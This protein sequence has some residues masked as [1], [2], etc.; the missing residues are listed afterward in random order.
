MFMFTIYQ[1]FLGC[2]TRQMKGKWSVYKG[3]FKKRRQM[4]E[5]YIGDTH[6]TPLTF[7][8]FG[9]HKNSY[10]LGGIMVSKV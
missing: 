2:I 4:W 10:F 9:F 3:R 1:R 7:K 5:F 8:F 6:Y